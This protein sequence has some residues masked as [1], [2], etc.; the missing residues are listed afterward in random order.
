[1]LSEDID[2]LIRL[3][4]ADQTKT[5]PKAKLQNAPTFTGSGSY[6]HVCL[7]LVIKIEKLVLTNCVNDSRPIP[8][9]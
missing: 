7:F 5:H 8:R 1:L 3:Q 4:H 9:Y 6:F 2:L